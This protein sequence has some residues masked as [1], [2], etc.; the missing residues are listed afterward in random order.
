[1]KKF[2]FCLKSVENKRTVSRRSTGVFQKLEERKVFGTE[3]IEQKGRRFV[4]V[5]RHILSWI[6]RF[7][8]QLIFTKQLRQNFAV[9]DDLRQQDPL[10]C[11]YISTKL[12]DVNIPE[13]GNCMV[14]AVRTSNDMFAQLFFYLRTSIYVTIL[15]V[16]IPLSSVVLVLHTFIYAFNHSLPFM[17]CCCCCLLLPERRHKIGCCNFLRKAFSLRSLDL[18]V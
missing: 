6:L 3:D 11:R 18:S 10:K 9:L 1:M 15:T 2:K 4:R 5:F 12:T 13:G 7:S 14:T 8:R 17:H 16:L